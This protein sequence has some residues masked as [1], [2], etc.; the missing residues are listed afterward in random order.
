LYY[1]HFTGFRVMTSN[2][3]RRRV[4]A[5]FSKLGRFSIFSVFIMIST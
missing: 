2:D 1:G 5:S 3:C 4:S